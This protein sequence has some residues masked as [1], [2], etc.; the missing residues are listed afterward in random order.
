[1]NRQNTEECYELTVMSRENVSQTRL[2]PALHHKGDFAY[3]SSAPA[4]ARRQLNGKLE[5]KEITE[6][7]TVSLRVVRARSPFLFHSVHYQ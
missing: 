2:P 6:D 4:S 5:Q 3:Q 1:M 7:L